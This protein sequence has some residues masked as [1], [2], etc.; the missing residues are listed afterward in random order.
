MTYC[1]NC[2]NKSHDDFLKRTEIDEN[3]RIYEIVVCQ[4]NRIE[5]NIEIEENDE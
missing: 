1:M 5:E 3:G 2:G 4:Y